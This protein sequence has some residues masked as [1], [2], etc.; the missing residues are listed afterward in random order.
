MEACIRMAV[1]SHVFI[2][3]LKVLILVTSYASV[4]NLVNELLLDI[5]FFKLCLNL[6]IQLFPECRPLD[7]LLTN[8]LSL[9]LVDFFLLLPYRNIHLYGSSVLGWRWKISFPQSQG[10]LFLKP[11]KDVIANILRQVPCLHTSSQGA[12]TC[13]LVRL[14]EKTCKRIAS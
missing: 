6:L 13:C 8:H 9:F 14:G 11:S 2:Q 10:S 5:W 7:F 1:K 4:R 3:V 12:H